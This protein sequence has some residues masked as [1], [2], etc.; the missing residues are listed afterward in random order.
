MPLCAFYSFF[1]GWYVFDGCCAHSFTLREGDDVEVAAFA[2]PLAPD[3]HANGRPPLVR[4]ERIVRVAGTVW[5]HA[6]RFTYAAAVNVPTGCSIVH[7]AAEAVATE[8]LPVGALFA[9][10]LVVH[11]CCGIVSSAAQAAAA[12]AAGAAAAAAAGGGAGEASG[13]ARCQHLCRRQHGQQPGH[14]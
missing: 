9:T 11:A 10:A 4:I 6:R 12:A 5:L 3:P 7:L 13:A 8:V 2:G 14:H 1:L